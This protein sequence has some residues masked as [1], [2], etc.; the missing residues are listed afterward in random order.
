VQL[1][2]EVL[3]PDFPLVA[4]TAVILTATI[5]TTLAF[6]LAIGD[7]FDVVRQHLAALGAPAAPTAGAG[8]IGWAGTLA[9]LRTASASAPPAFRPTLLR[10]CAC[11][12][13]SA[14]GNAVVAYLAP[15][16]GERFG[17]RMRTRLMQEILSKRQSFFDANPKGDLMARLTLDV[18][19]LQ[20]TL[21][22]FVGQ[23]GFRSMMEVA[24][25][26]GMM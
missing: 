9:A 18:T 17:A 14:A 22:D 25:S 3:R 20:G 1:A 16:L 5:A 19:V 2:L 15:L 13:A 8:G 21:A 10:L 7:L 26:L 24:F 12:V 6:P 23:R 11:L 4:L